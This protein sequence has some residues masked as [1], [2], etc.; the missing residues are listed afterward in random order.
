MRGHEVPDGTEA[1]GAKGCH[2]ALC[3]STYVTDILVLCLVA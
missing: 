3:S 2:A 1:G